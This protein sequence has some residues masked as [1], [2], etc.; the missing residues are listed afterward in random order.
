MNPANPDQIDSVLRLIDREVWVITSAAAG[1]RGGLTA[2]WVS[3]ASIDREHPVLLVGIAPNHF[4]AELI[5]HS[6]VFVAHLLTADQSE[7]AWNFTRDSGRQRDKL[8]GLEFAPAGSGAPL[9]RECL[10]WLDCRVFARYD[11][12]D[13]LFYWADVLAGAQVSA[14]T[15]LREH[16]LVAGLTADQRE[17]LLAA[18]QADITAIRPLG[19]N[20]RKLVGK[21][22]QP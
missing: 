12:G 9:L 7:L 16:A 20:W 11:A 5:E 19:K 21:A 6:H 14:G 22:E 2:T 15:P 18:R 13:R 17:T 10:A 8:A 1:R 4:T 3:P